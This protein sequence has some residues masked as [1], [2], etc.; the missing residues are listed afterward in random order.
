MAP[1]DE[2]RELDALGAT[3]VEERLDRC[4]HR[5]S[6]VKHVVDDHHRRSR[7]VELDVRGVEHRSLGADREIVAV[8]ADVD[9]ADGD[10]L[11]AD[12]G[13]DPVQTPCEDRAATV[14]SDQRRKP[15]RIALDDLVADAREG[16][17][18]VVGAQNH[19]R[20]A[21]HALLPGLTGPG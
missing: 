16:A 10:V 15:V 12:A 5:A 19:A 11:A 14:N 9:I 4:A 3:V 18:D 21:C 17:V 8:E 20:V 13:E 2:Y 7:D 6:R 1:V